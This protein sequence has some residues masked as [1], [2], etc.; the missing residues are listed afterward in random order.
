[1]VDVQSMSDALAGVPLFA[2]LD[3]E[4]LASL[5]RGMR[6]RRF[7]RGETVFHVGDPGDAL[8]VVITGSIKITL[9]G[10]VRGANSTDVGSGTE[11]LRIQAPRFHPVRGNRPSVLP[12]AMTADR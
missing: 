3:P 9:P 11:Y 7:R 4:G 12:A 10:E 1:M 6:I 8:F 2:G 5:V